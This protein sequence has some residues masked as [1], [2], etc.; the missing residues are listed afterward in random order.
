M[1]VVTLSGLNDEQPLPEELQAIADRP[2]IPSSQARFDGHRIYVP[3]GRAK[4]M[5]TLAPTTEG[6]EAKKVYAVGNHPLLAYAGF[7]LVGY[8]LGRQMR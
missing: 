2:P 7:A 4:H 1:R 5:F 8:L 6:G 3:V